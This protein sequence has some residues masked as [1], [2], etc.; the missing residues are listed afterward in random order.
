MPPINEPRIGAKQASAIFN[1]AFAF[2]LSM[3]PSAGFPQTVGIYY[4][5]LGHDRFGATEWK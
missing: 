4:T 1:A 2:A 5:P 3:M